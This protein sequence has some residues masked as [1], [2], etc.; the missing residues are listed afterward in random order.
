MRQQVLDQEKRCPQVQPD[1]G[2]PLFLRD[3]IDAAGAEGAGVIDEDV[4]LWRHGRDTRGGGANA[5]HGGQVVCEKRAFSVRRKFRREGV[6]FFGR[7]GDDDHV[8]TGFDERSGDHGANSPG[9]AGDHGGLSFNGEQAGRGI[10][11]NHG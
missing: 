2:L 1:V 11:T 8:G 10:R 9:P 7:A 6:A 3:V 5:R 4:Q